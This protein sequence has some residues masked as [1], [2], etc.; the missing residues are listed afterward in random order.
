MCLLS[1][2]FTIKILLCS[3]DDYTAKIWSLKADKCVHD[4]REHSKEIYTIKW[5][6]TGVGT[7]NPN[8]TPVLASA[9]FDATIKVFSQVRT[10][11]HIHSTYVA[12]ACVGIVRCRH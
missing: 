4:L 10:R 12:C 1:G 5:S 11:T 8:K 3:S 6:P 2:F 9:S 7:D